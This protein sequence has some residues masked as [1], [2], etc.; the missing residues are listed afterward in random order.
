MVVNPIFNN[1]LVQK[2]KAGKLWLKHFDDLKVNP[3]YGLTDAIYNLLYKYRKAWYDF[4]YKS[5]QQIITMT[6]LMKCFRNQF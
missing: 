6:R 4:I 2:T 3:E 5:K 1:Q